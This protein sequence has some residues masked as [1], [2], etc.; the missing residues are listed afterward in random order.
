MYNP[1]YVCVFV[2]MLCGRGLLLGQE[3][4]EGDAQGVGAV[5]DGK[6]GIGWRVTR[7]H[8]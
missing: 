8:G 7:E 5:D 6:V 1:M 3:V 4:V 2:R